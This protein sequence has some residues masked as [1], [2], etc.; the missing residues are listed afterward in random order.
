MHTPEIA[1]VSVAFDHATGDRRESARRVIIAVPALAG[2]GFRGCEVALETKTASL[3]VAIRLAIGDAEDA[4]QRLRFWCARAGGTTGIPSAAGD[5]VQAAWRS[6]L[7][8][9]LRRTRCSTADDLARVLDEFLGPGLSL[10]APER[11]ALEIDACGPGAAGMAYDR[12][13]RLLFIPGQLAPPLGDAFELAARV[14]GRPAPVRCSARVVRVR[15][16]A[17]GVGAPA[18]FVLQ[19]G[20]AASSI[21]DALSASCAALNPDAMIEEARRAAPRYA[22]R[23]AVEIERSSPAELGAPDERRRGHVVSLSV[24]GAFVETSRPEPP[25]AAL[26]LRF[27]VPD[28]ERFT[29]RATVVYATSAGVGVKFHLDAA[30]ETALCRLLSRISARPRRALIVDDDALVRR[31]LGDALAHRG[32]EVLS[33]ASGEDAVR[34]L[35]SELFALDA[36]VTDLRMDGL[37]GSQIVQAVSSA[38]EQLDIA[39]VVVSGRLDDDHVQRLGG[40][41]ADAVLD[42]AMTPDGIAEAVDALVEQRSALRSRTAPEGIDA[43]SPPPRH[44]TGSP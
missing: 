35:A 37:D 18:G 32:Y 13:H 8:T 30:A 24:G 9:A 21:T 25:G 23:I 19:L 38:R 3:L 41:G 31:M 39:V 7:S 40:A 1:E 26:L 11:P 43:L 28:R 27:E 10:G 34:V 17:L 16:V 36:I 12:H 6:R 15:R 2:A 33:A 22:V 44:G 14:P 42:K 20:A 5:A 4:I 29:V